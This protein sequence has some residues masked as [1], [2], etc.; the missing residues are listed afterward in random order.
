MLGAAV[1][2]GL[3][4]GA[5]TAPAAGAVDRGAPRGAEAAGA[6]KTGPKLDTGS[7]VRVN[8]VGYLTHGPKK[9]TVV[10]R[11]TKPLT[12]TLRAADDTKRAS[13]TTTPAGVDPSSRQNV[14]TFDFSRVTDKGEG[15][16]V[17]IDGKKSEPFS[18]GDD[19]YSSLRR[20]SL[21]YF[22]QNR[23]GI[24]IDAA[25]VGGKYARPAGHGKAAPHRGDTD[26]PC[27]QG[28]CDYRR[29]V[30]GGWYDAGDQGKYVV[31]GGISVAQLMSEFERTRT[32]KGADAKPLGD[33]RLRVPE[34]GNG[35]PDILDEARWE[36][37]FLMRMQVPQGKPLAGMAF[38]KVHDKQWTG[39]PTR[40]DQDKQQRE[41]HAPSTAAT[42]NLAATAAQSAR[43]FKPYD[44]RF[45]ARSLHVAKAAW[46]AA[47]AHPH[48]IAG[49]Q[50]STGG[51]AYGDSDVNDEFYWAGAELFITTGDNTYRQAVLQSPLYGDVDAIFPRTSALSWASTAGLGALDLATV[52]NK[53]TDKQRADVR[54]TVIRA[55]DRYAADSA[56]SDYGVPYAPKG[57]RY[58]W[59]SNSQVLNNMV[60]LAT[61]HDL[62]GKTRYRDAVLRG[63][64]YLLGAN[65]LDQSYVTGY[66]ERNSH[67]QH[68]RFWAH[69]IDAKL[70]SPAP[71]T[72]AGGPNSG[73]QDPVAQ[74][75]LKGCAPAMCY[76]DD[77][78]AFSTNEVTINWNAPLAWI[79][80][81]VDDLGKGMAYKG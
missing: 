46:A 66:G 20:D 55:A 62:T 34:H 58:E 26:V 39:F 22:Y 75:K 27:R 15:Y 32:T 81:Y 10:T 16:T 21:D 56:K 12:W 60:V 37:D 7:P 24:K 1:A 73:L 29:N 79:S 64:D 80:S 71:G 53:L 14:Q 77:I 78:M 36:M 33:G 18:I 43:L 74:K 41:L 70:P 30:S 48:M 50:D 68:H 8:Q 44:P 13:G 76:I 72:L 5:L 4:L 54:K 25:L 51:G 28:V 47:K 67:H 17:T 61:A 6:E 59:G 49:D 19:L 9:G 69:Q 45:A 31:N 35:I 38:H 23:S 40:P 63:L 3:A 42:L 52:D 11:A 65:P 2:A 57:G